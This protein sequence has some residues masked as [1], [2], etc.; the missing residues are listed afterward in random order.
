MVEVIFS[1]KEE[2]NGLIPF[3]MDLEDLID[4]IH[5]ILTFRLDEVKPKL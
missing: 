5:L 3:G 1:L 2:R 4:F